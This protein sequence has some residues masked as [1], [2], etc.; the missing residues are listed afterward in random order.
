M[1]CQR[2]REY[3]S[4]EVDLI[5]NLPSNPLLVKNSMKMTIIHS[6]SVLN[7]LVKEACAVVCKSAETIQLTS[8][9]KTIFA[10]L[11]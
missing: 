9:M 4:C 3:N 6:S 2:S 5:S 11:F 8:K 1:F 7:Y 10:V